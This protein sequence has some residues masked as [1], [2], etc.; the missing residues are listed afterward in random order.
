[1]SQRAES[2]SPDKVKKSGAHQNPFVFAVSV[3]ILVILAISFLWGPSLSNG[4]PSPIAI[5]G[6]YDGYEI[7]EVEN[8][9]FMNQAYNYSQQYQS[10][11]IYTLSRVLTNSFEDSVLHFA[12]L[13]KAKELG[14]SLSNRAVY[15]ELAKYP[16][17]QDAKGNFDADKLQDRADQLDII[18]Q[19]REQL[20]HDYLMQLIVNGTQ[21]SEQESAF[22][23][24]TYAKRRTFDVVV[25][26]QKDYPDSEVLAFANANQDKF[27]QASLASIT[28][29]DK[30]S[31]DRVFKELEANPA[32]FAELAKTNSLD[33]NKENGGAWDP[34]FLYALKNRYT[35]EAL[36]TK[37][38]TLKANE[39]YGP[40]SVDGQ[41][42]I[43]KA[44]ADVK[45]PALSSP[46]QIETIRS[47][48]ASQER[49]KLEDY[50]SQKARSF[51]SSAR[52][53][54]FAVQA[55]SDKRTVLGTAELAINTRP[56][57]NFDP[58]TIQSFY[59]PMAIIPA[60]RLEDGTALNGANT[61]DE[62]FINGFSLKAGEVSD[63]VVLNGQVVVLSLKEE[64]AADES[65][66]G[67]FAA[68]LENIVRQL[69]TA[70]I[71]RTVVDKKK[72]T[73]LYQEGVRKWMSRNNPTS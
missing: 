6:I 61:K 21:V 59:G 48:I 19:T 53:A 68:Y 27:S 57:G 23:K 36:V 51:V 10:N 37:L 65:E 12:L 55:G 46:E 71:K 24:E 34:T 52:T 32:N 63:P 9:Y 60:V 47:Y 50:L 66:A 18:K 22:F 20:T 44:I 58:F 43:V 56:S 14:L 69:N 11:D 72:L 33:A 4:T 5:F 35:D 25:F 42:L 30:A 13:S 3:A 54:G 73:D 7:N 2:N 17:F 38:S 40:V 8:S 39:L 41:Y 26:D 28:L 1:M 29:G 45:A 70:D 31:A 49:G 62:F 16:A 67:L 15:L 64:K